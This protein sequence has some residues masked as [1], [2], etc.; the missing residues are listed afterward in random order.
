[1]SPVV[2]QLVG[3]FLSVELVRNCL[4]LARLYYTSQICTYHL[5]FYFY[6]FLSV[7][8]WGCHLRFS[9]VVSRFVNLIPE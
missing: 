1:M 2:S 6:M 7:V 4:A 5:I 8:I 3:L 9:A